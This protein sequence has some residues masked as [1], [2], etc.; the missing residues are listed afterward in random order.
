MGRKSNLLLRERDD[1]RTSYSRSV[2][3]KHNRTE[4]CGRMRATR[5]QGVG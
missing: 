2:F 5:K 1:K 4:F 3:G